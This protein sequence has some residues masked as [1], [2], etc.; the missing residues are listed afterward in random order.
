MLLRF[1]PVFCLAVLVQN[2]ALAQ[3]QNVLIGTDN[4]PNEPSICINP[5]NPRQLVAGANIDNI[6]YSGDGGETWQQT[7]VACPWGV[8]GDPVIGIDTAGAFYFLHLSNPPAPGSWIDRIIAQ[9]S[10]DGGQTW[11]AGS[12][13]GLNGTR[14]QDKHWIATDWKTNALYVT[15][16]Q[17]DKYGSPSP[18]DSSVILFSKSTDG[19]A[20][21]SAARR[22]S[23]LAGDCLDSDLTAEG[24]MP[25][26]GPNGEVFV[27][28]SNRNKIWFDRSLDG[29][30]TWLD[31][32]VFVSDQPG[33]WDFDIP[34]IYRAN[35]LPVT[36]C[37]TSGGAHHGTIYINWTDQR[38]GENNT[39]V[40][41]AKSIDGGNNWSAPVRVNNDTSTRHQFFTWMTIDQKT[42]W[43]W[44]VFYD[45]RN[46]PDK[47]TD[48][49]MAVSKDGGETFQNF[50]VSESPFLPS[51]AFFFGDYT[52][53]T[54]ANN[55]V[56]P[57]WTRLDGNSL[58]VWTALVDPSVL[59]STGEP[60]ATAGTAFSVENP[61]PNPFSETTG[62]SFRLYR[63]ALV[64]LSLVDLQ[65]NL[66]ARLIDREWR[67][68]GKYLEKIEPERL[69]IS[70]GM[71]F[72][73]LDVDGKI[74]RRKI[75][76]AEP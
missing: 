15:W 59:V 49:F 40:W 50:K 34:G 55:V 44:F 56:R 57:I 76:F 67:G 52:N 45:R 14:A 47:Q 33:G 31:E 27:A 22:I 70:P 42:G 12:F 60:T 29:G 74:S 5:K 51:T 65:G 17:F 66:R 39:D 24:A 11:S 3:H 36:T 19:G 41:L 9:K 26:V 32:D 58:S 48:V 75:V 20:S 13:M 64:S 1:I 53:I 69:G 30:A 4:A 7:P 21:W 35:G 10:T 71:Y 43:L 68:T 6:Y 37:D 62:F 25:A 8:W 28:W 38:N 72:I 18:A 63:R 73:L 61:Y 54:A 2:L 46:Y 16:T 23:K